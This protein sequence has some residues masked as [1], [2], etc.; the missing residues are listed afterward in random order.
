MFLI[1]K[2]VY[3]QRPQEL[4]VGSSSLRFWR[5]FIVSKN[6]MHIFPP[7]ISARKTHFLAALKLIP[8]WVALFLLKSGIA[9]LCSSIFR[10]VGT[11]ASALANSLTSNKDLHVIF[12]YFFYG[13]ALLVLIIILVWQ[14]YRSWVK[15]WCRG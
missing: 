1:R 8:Q 12:N 7:Q 3:F 6:K 15:W 5:I 2:P 9:D 13:E 4:R 11:N 14:F 10:L